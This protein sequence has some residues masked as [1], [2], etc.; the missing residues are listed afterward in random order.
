MKTDESRGLDDATST[1]QIK[2]MK[3]V[4]IVREISEGNNNTIGNCTKVL[5][6]K[7]FMRMFSRRRGDNYF[8]TIEC[9]QSCLKSS[10][11]IGHP[12]ISKFRVKPNKQDPEEHIRYKREV[13]DDSNI[14]MVLQSIIH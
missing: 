1:R 3:S 9:V 13:V 12:L 6:E 10:K 14:E 8:K 11:G 7:D 5:N 2:P 4:A